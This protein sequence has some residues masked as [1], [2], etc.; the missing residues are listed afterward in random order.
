MHPIVAQLSPSAEQYPAVHARGQDVA[1]TAGAGTGKTRTLAARYLSLLADGLPLRGI[2]AITFTQKAAREMRNRVRETMRKFVDSGTSERARWLEIYSRFDAARI[3]TIHGLCAEILAAHP[4]EANIAP[5]FAVLD[6]GQ[7]AVLRGQAVAEGMAWAANQSAITPLFAQIAPYHLQKLLD[8]LLAQR[9]ETTDIFARLPSASLLKYWDEILTTARN[10]ARNALF[11][12]PDWQPAVDFV[13]DT[14]PNN[15]ADKLATQREL[16]LEAVAG[17]LSRLDEI[18]LSGGAGKNWDGGKD[19]VTA[20][21]AAIKTIRALWRTQRDILTL[22]LTPADEA[23]AAVMPALAQLFDAAATRYERAKIEREALDFDDLEAK[24]LTLLREHAAVRDYWQSEIRALLVDEFQD[25]NARQRDLLNLLDGGGGKRFIVGDAKQSI[26]RFRGADVTVFRAERDAI[27][28]AGTHV[29]LDTSYRAHADLIAGMNGLLAPVLGI[30]ADPAEPWRE[31]FAALKPA[32]PDPRAG[33]SAPHIEFHLTGGSKSD[34]A[35]DAAANALAARLAELAATPG[36]SFG[37]MAILCRAASSFGA[38]EDALERAAIP[39]VTVAGGGFY[40]R[41]EIRDCLNALQAIADPTDNVALAGF[42]RS[43][44][45]GVSDSTLF[46]LFDAPSAGSPIIIEKL[47][48]SVATTGGDESVRLTRAIRLLTA[49]H[50]RAGRIPVADLL[51]AWLDATDYLAA[52]LRAGQKRAARN[53]R[54]LLNDAHASGL[55]GVEEFLAYVAN[56][57]D[58]GS[59]EGEARVTERGAVQLMTIHAA[60]GLEFPVVVVGDAGRSE[61]KQRGTLSDAE[62]GILYPLKNEDGSLPS[63]LQLGKQREVAKSSAES[64]RLLYVAA[65]RAQEKLIFSGTFNVS[66][67][68]KPMFNGW[69]KELLAENN[70]AFPADFSCDPEGAARHNISLTASGSIPVACVVY[71]PSVPFPA[72]KSKLTPAPSP[73]DMSLPLVSPVVDGSAAESAPDTPPRVWRVVPATARASAPAWVVGHAVHAALAQWRFP[74]DP[75]F[76]A[77]VAGLL[78][79]AGLLDEAQIRDGLARVSRI[80]TRFREHPLYRTMANASQRWHEVPYTLTVDG[81]PETGVMD[82]L[83]E[84]H[85]RWTIVEFK[86]DIIHGDAERDAILAQR[87]YPAQIARYRRA[88]RQLLGQEPSALLC[89]LN[90]AGRVVV[91]TMGAP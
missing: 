67:G 90:F 65:T 20:V 47:P 11:A 1:V 32:R 64:A 41:P 75:A 28:A 12:H 37:D 69:L 71:E 79:N 15:P 29:A 2:V 61:P 70:L 39:F 87:D 19:T 26:Y 89:W 72:R 45:I 30:T 80:L 8:A 86:T 82:A 48:L 25:T 83:F 9:L 6:E 78:R 38:Y 21:K 17:D 31:P 73:A 24:T 50:G 22:T 56:L 46:K 16:V 4:A 63:V 23:L 57:R 91:E 88:V 60:K 34:G 43:P 62:L 7:M 40:R 33:F 27:R 54:K 36:I 76:S 14:T 18:N 77:W 13:R 58:S 81:V 53:V 68:G 44:V 49:L 52:L 85:G 10:T 42:L 84:Q 3:S 66:R 74:D 51:K 35:L 59:R 5:R 55:V